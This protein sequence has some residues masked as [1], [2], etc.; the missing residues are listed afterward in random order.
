MFGAL[1][2]M[3]LFIIEVYFSRNFIQFDKFNE[4]LVSQYIHPIFSIDFRP[5]KKDMISKI[6]DE[7]LLLCKV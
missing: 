6:S 3:L 2:A 5:L 1:E 7:S 4:L